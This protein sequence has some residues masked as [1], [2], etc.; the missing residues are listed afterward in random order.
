MDSENMEKEK[1]VK[2]RLSLETRKNV[3]ASLCKLMRA[4]YNGTID[5]VIFRDMV[6]SFNALLA[7]DKLDYEA[8]T[9]KRL[10]ALEKY[11]RGESGAV[12]DGKDIDNPYAADLKMQLIREAKRNEQLQSE[13]MELRQQIAKLHG[14]TD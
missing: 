13:I 10:E 9:N 1:V 7:G 12:V 8:E 2:K 3:R 5:T 6:Y 4:R 11:I 14:T